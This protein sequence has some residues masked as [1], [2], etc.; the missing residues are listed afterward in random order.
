MLGGWHAINLHTQQICL[1]STLSFRIF[2][3]RRG[4]HLRH[5]ISSLANNMDDNQS[6]IVTHAAKMGT[7][8]TQTQLTSMTETGTGGNMSKDCLPPVTTAVSIRPVSDF[9]P[10]YQSLNT[11]FVS[12]CSHN[13]VQLFCKVCQRLSPHSPFGFWWVPQHFLLQSVI[14][15]AWVKTWN[16]WFYLRSW[17]RFLR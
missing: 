10:C 15:S 3:R 16:S 13:S 12:L 14:S 5:N 8:D 9:L 4:H 11:L 6:H 17:Y 1:T 7:P 2:Q